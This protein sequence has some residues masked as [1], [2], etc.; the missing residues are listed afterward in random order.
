MEDNHMKALWL[1][2]CGQTPAR[3][4]HRMRGALS[5]QAKKSP[6][7]PL[8]P[9]LSAALVLLLLLGSAYALERLGV[10]D[11]LSHALKT[12]LLPE[13][14]EMVK[15]GIPQEAVQPA[16]ARFTVEEAVYDGR[17]AYFTL[18]VSPGDVEKVLLMDPDSGPAWAYDWQA[19]GNIYEGESFAE[20]AQA[21]GQKMVQAEVWDALV[22]EE[23]QE[24]RQ[25][26]LR[27]QN[28]DLL[29]TLSL[30]AQGDEARIRL[31]LLAMDIYQQMD[32]SARGSL[33]FTLQKSPLSR[34]ALAQTPLPL[35]KAGL[36]LTY[37]QVELSPIAS[38]LTL[39]YAL[40]PDA[41]PIQAVNFQD[42]LWAEWL[43]E[44]GNSRES[45]DMQQEIIP[46]PDGSVE[47]TQS[48]GA[49]EEM[50]E[51]ITL[52]FYHGMSKE[53][54]DQITLPIIPKEER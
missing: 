45:G 20:K 50:P 38:Y 54:F 51:E 18:R 17:Q 53:R 23:V 44:E 10:L 25:H 35:P 6:A 28:G 14:S 42:G 40:A 39:R 27:Y 12:Q 37:C 7:R 13:A 24:T 22:N 9:A 30:P 34:E 5:A 21:A 15:S 46:L 16:L 11:T 32:E 2:A 31:N 3:F 29:Y 33:A 26:H 41:A 19:S 1:E 49:L 48:F 47:L 4:S 52:S 36:M 8:R 43:D